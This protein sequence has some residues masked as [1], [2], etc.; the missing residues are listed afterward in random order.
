[1]NKNINIS[2]NLSTTV[3]ESSYISSKVV[4]SLIVDESKGVLS[5][6]YDINLNINKKPNSENI[7]I[8]SDISKLDTENKKVLAKCLHTIIDELVGGESHE[9]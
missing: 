9:N 6:A 2:I 7:S 4:N 5:I 1:M 8:S 3:D